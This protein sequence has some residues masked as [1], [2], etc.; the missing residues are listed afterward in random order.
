[1]KKLLVLLL[2]AMLLNLAAD[3]Q[4]G[5]AVLGKINIG[6]DS[7]YS[8]NIGGSQTPA[9][10]FPGGCN[11]ACPIY[12]FIGAGNWNIPGNWSAN[13]IPPVVLDG[14]RQIVINPAGDNECILNIPYQVLSPGTTLTVMSQ[15]K[16]R[17]P[18]SI[19]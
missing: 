5:K 17:V 7:L 6:R 14:C 2:A 1:M 3:A 16:F 15:K 10:S 9:C 13:M 8:S 19:R 4:V 11:T 18:G 12:T